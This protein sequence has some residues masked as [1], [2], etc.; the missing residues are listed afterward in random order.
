VTRLGWPPGHSRATCLPERVLSG[1]IPPARACCV[2]KAARL[3]RRRRRSAS[4]PPRAARTG[5]VSWV[6]AC[7]RMTS[8]GG[9]RPN[10][11]QRHAREG[12]HPRHARTSRRQKRWRSPSAAPKHDCCWVS[13]GEARRDLRPSR[14]QAMCRGSSPARGGRRQEATGQPT[15]NVMPA[16]AG[17]HDTPELCDVR[18]AGDRHRLPRSVT[19]VGS[20]QAQARR[21]LHPPRER[22]MCRASS[23]ARG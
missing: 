4:G 20:A 18:S 11:P 21:G 3:S 19:A 12:G 9:S 16:K 15:T 23:P 5:N 14:E 17:T 1:A 13:A 6:L 22:A 2:P 7:A 10:T 8:Q